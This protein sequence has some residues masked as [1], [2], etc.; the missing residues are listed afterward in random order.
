MAIAL[1]VSAAQAQNRSCNGSI[2]QA[3]QL[4]INRTAL[5]TRIT[6]NSTACRP[7]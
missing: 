1:F 7:R 5:Y 2:C 4:E 3:A 6:M